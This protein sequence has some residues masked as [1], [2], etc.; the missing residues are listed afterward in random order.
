LKTYYDKRSRMVFLEIH[1]NGPGI[2]V[3]KQDKI[4]EPLFTE[5]KANGHGYGLAICRDIVEKHDGT[6]RVQSKP[7]EGTTFIIS[8]PFKVGDDYAQVEFDSLERLEVK[9]ARSLK[10]SIKAKRKRTITNPPYR[11]ISNYSKLYGSK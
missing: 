9:R 10:N 11:P 2:P 5:N 7:G 1:D 8:L 3:D 4:F 6:I